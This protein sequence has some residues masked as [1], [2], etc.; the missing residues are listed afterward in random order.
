MSCPLP[1]VRKGIAA[2]KQV[3]QVKILMG[4]LNNQLPR[5]IYLN[6]WINIV[7]PKKYSQISFKDLGITWT[8]FEQT[9]FEKGI[10]MDMHVYS[11][12]EERVRIAVRNIRFAKETWI[13]KH[14]FG[15]G[16]SKIHFLQCFLGKSEFPCSI[17]KII[18]SSFP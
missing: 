10:R 17:A 2:I 1:F 14:I 7:W 12:K 11:L 8:F 18:S 5:Q 15:W 3:D 4:Y 13:G 16:A 9:V 6:A